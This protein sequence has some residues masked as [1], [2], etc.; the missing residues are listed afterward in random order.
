M[1]ESSDPKFTIQL[2]RLQAG[3]S[4]PHRIKRRDKVHQKI[5]RLKPQ[6]SAA[7]R[8]DDIPVITDDQNP[9]NAK[10]IT[11]SWNTI[12]DSL[13]D[14]KRVTGDDRRI[15]GTA[16][17]VCRAGFAEPKQREIDEALGINSAPGGVRKSKA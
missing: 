2:E 9:P 3:L 17:H 10:G 5:G 6:Y 13:N 8:H 4:R 1:Q 15:D 11:D 12:R 14:H 16:G 7:R